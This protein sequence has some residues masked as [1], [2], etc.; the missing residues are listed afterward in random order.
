[1]AQNCRNGGQAGPGVNH[2]GG[3]RVPKVVDDERHF[4]Q[5]RSCGACSGAVAIGSR[6]AGLRRM[7]SDTIIH[8]FQ[9]SETIG[10][11]KSRVI[12][13]DAMSFF[14]DDRGALHGARIA[15]LI[16]I[17][18][19]IYLFTQDHSG[20]DIRRWVPRI[21]FTLGWWLAFCGKRVA[22]TTADT[23]TVP[24]R[25]IGFAL[26]LLGLLSPFYGQFK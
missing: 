1:M 6:T 11:P 18:S 24:H 7:K 5:T 2:A 26:A 9:A 12:A 23:L 4:R 13:M 16:F 15:G 8:R 3:E 19:G 10:S 14:K 17:A 20:Q 25:A 21:A 22:R